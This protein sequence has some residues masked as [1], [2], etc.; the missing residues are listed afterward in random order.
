MRQTDNDQTDDTNNSKKSY[1]LDDNDFFTI[2]IANRTPEIR[3][4]PYLYEEK[5]FDLCKTIEKDIAKYQQN[6]ENNFSLLK[7]IL[8]NFNKKAFTQSMDNF[9]ESLKKSNE[10]KNNKGYC[11]NTVVDVL[12]AAIEA[13]KDR[14]KENIAI[15]FALDGTLR[16]PFDDPY[17][18]KKEIDSNSG[19]KDSKDFIEKDITMEF[20]IDTDFVTEYKKAK[21]LGI[22]IFGLTNACYSMEKQDKAFK[23]IGIEFDSLSEKSE[24][25]KIASLFY[26]AEE[27]TDLNEKIETTAL[28]DDGFKDTHFHYEG[29]IT[30][31]NKIID[32]K[33]ETL[34]KAP[35]LLRAIDLIDKK[36]GT[37]DKIFYVDSD[38]S[39][40]SDAAY[41]FSQLQEEKYKKTQ[42]SLIFNYYND[43]FPGTRMTVVSL[44]GDYPGILYHV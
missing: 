44:Q 13:K 32:N 18:F 10:S 7:E 16:K 22:L 42:L 23:R 25:I 38:P 17:L 39:Q 20:F 37:P 4:H 40:L 24:D 21:E 19:E 36:F 35:C 1:T 5:P 12:K 15:F 29:I 41:C 6:K 33:K 27:E 8:Y 2:Y 9:I 26:S 14:P 31:S 11:F 43:A 3:N 30:A 34:S 28:F